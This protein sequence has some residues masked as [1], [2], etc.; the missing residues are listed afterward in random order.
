MSEATLVR[1]RIVREP[2]ADVIDFPEPVRLCGDH[3]PVVVGVMRDA[4]VE[5]RRVWLK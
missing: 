2:P 4:P 1:P 5:L 3:G